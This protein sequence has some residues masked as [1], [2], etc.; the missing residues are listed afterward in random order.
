LNSNAQV[1]TYRFAVLESV[2]MLKEST[3]NRAL[4]QRM[5]QVSRVVVV[6]VVATSEGYTD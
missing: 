6:V 2:A 3:Q 4:A 5:R 1:V